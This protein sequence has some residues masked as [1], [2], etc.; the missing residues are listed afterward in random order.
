MRIVF[1]GS[2]IFSKRI[3]EKLISLKADIIGVCTNEKSTFNADFVDLGDLSRENSIPCLHT[4]DINSVDSVSWIRGKNPDI[5]FCF[6][7]SS[8]IKKEL[9]GL[10]PKGVIGYH[11]AKLPF[12]R[13][14][15]PLIWPIV[16]GMEQSTSTFFFMDEGADSGDILSERDFIILQEDD[17]QSIYEKAV[18]LA[19]EQV[20]EFVPL[21]KN[22]SYAKS[23]Q[24]YQQAGYFRKRGKNDGRI[25]FRMTSRAIYDLVRG[26]T[27]P[28]VGAHIETKA[29]DIKVWRSRL[30]DK[31]NDYLEPGRV[32]EILGD[33]IR[34]KTYDGYIDLVDHGFSEM[35]KQGDYL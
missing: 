2:V 27:R 9:L 4:S 11:P 7:W 19:S 35:P 22:N 20:E 32:V 23:P 28:Y 26:L 18:L 10:A 3:L 5:I 30:I 21:L 33:S 16:L 29:G 15:H 24:N 31:E 34:V 14:R 6:G 1:I 25:D 17:A 8:L 12:F 13:G